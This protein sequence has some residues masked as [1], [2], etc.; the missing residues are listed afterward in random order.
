MLLINTTL[1]VILA[2]YIT[3]S[4]SFKYLFRQ[5]FAFYYFEISFMH[6]VNEP[7]N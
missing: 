5:G 2:Y 7:I 4:A 3:T 6:L 1:V